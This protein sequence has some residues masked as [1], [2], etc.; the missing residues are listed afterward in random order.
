M[1]HP[2]A[3]S[4]WD[5]ECCQPSLDVAQKEVWCSNSSLH[6]FTPLKIN[7]KSETFKLD[8]EEIQYFR[9]FLGEE[10]YWRPVMVSVRSI[11][12][13]HQ[14]FMSPV[15]PEPTYDLAYS[16]HFSVFY[17][18]NQWSFAQSVTNICP[19]TT[20]YTPGTYGIGISAF[21]A[22]EFY[23]EILSSPLPFPLPAPEEKVSC[24]SVPDEVYEVSNRTGRQVLCLEDGV[25]T[26]FDSTQ[27]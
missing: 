16:D 2:Q 4:C 5:D 17:R 22:T 7:E 3:E 1:D 25:T 27:V 6:P 12:G 15:F 18:Q 11:Y 23:F 19:G 14:F 26:R 20:I 24:D 8:A 21:E 10:V 13:N 9:F